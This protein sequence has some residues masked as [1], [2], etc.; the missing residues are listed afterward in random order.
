M[1]VN[2]R[3]AMTTVETAISGA[4]SNEARLGQVLSSAASEADRL[5][6][7]L[8]DAFR[9]LALVR[10]DDLMRNQVVGELDAAERRAV[11]LMRSHKARL[12]QILIRCGGAQSVV[13]AAEADS[14]Q[15][16]AAVL[17]ARAPITALQQRVESEMKADPAWSAQQAAAKA[18]LD[19]ANAADAKADQAEADRDTKRKPYEGDPLFMYLWTSKFSTAD[20]RAGNFARF[21]DRKVAA[22]VDFATAR[23]NYVL[24]NE[25][26][27]RLREH[28]NVALKAAQDEDLRLEDIERAALVKAGIAPLEAVLK[29]AEA[30]LKKSSDALSQAQAALTALDQE[31]TALQGE[32][33]RKAHEDALGVLSQA[34]ALESLQSLY[35]AARQTSTPEDDRL[36]QEIERT[37]N[38]VAKADADVARIRD[39]ARD[40]ARRRG[41]LE[42]VRDQMRSNRYDRPGNQFELNGPDVLGGLIGGIIGGAIQSGVMWELLRQAHRGR[43]R[44]DDDDDDD[45][46]GEGGEGGERGPWGRRDR[47]RFRFPNSSF[48]RSGGGGFGGGGFKTGGGFGGG[49]GGFRTGG[50]F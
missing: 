46:G 45:D 44:D 17:A 6:K 29:D 43:N 28:A 24:L 5:R 2:G 7:Q 36:V 48:P 34:L 18:A 32:G 38:A 25:I 35:Q 22:L 40:V 41:E 3:E 8:A 10:L 33:D 13:I 16:G 47:P 1:I 15:K 31:R 49:R 23:P 30:A 20:Y 39:E 26:P 19:V 21:F 4:R 14:R 42:N 9:G 37:E 50:K 27:E 11:D 12:D